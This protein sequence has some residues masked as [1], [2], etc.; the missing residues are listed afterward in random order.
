[1]FGVITGVVGPALLLAV[2]NTAAA[3]ALANIVLYAGVYTPLK[4]MHPINTWVRASHSSAYIHSFRVVVLTTPGLRAR[5]RVCV[6]QVGSVVGAIPPMIG[7]AA[8]TKGK[9][10]LG[11]WAL[12]THSRAASDRHHHHHRRGQNV[13]SSADAR[14]TRIWNSRRAPVPVADPPLPFALV[15]A[16]GGLCP[17]RLQD[18]LRHQR[19]RVRV[20]PPLL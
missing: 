19:R 16:E 13:I 12:G 11:A 9:L 5:V 18:A 8:V 15:S 7:W 17:S 20:T 2:D 6:V 1:M 10:D 14:H 4:Q 3:L